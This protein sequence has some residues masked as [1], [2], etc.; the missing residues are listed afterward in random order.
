M[1]IKFEVTDC[2]FTGD[3]DFLTQEIMKEV[4]PVYGK[5]HGFAIF[6]KDPRGQ[7]L[8]GCSGSIIFG[9]I[10][11]DQ[12]WVHP[13]H[14]GRGLGRQLMNKVHQ[15][16]KSQGCKVAAVETMDFQ[17]PQFYQKLGYRIDF[18][19]SGY[20]QGANCLFLSKILS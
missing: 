3:I 19:R 5:A 6:T 12:L 13:Q 20:N 11:T 2:P 4:P 10:Y 15:H 7:I 17:S 16:G 8:A 18:T 1:N 9:E 14:R